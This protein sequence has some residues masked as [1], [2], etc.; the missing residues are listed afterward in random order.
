[1]LGQVAYIN[2]KQYTEVDAGL[3]PTGILMPVAGSPFDFFSEPKPFGQDIA[4]VTPGYDHNY[5]LEGI[6]PESVPSIAYAF[7]VLKL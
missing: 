4:E 5:A 1:M 3:I 2:A 6:I 7:H